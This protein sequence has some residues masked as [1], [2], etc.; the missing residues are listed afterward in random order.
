MKEGSGKKGLQVKL[1][2][3]STPLAQKLDQV[4]SDNN[5]YPT[6]FWL[7]ELDTVE[8][9]NAIGPVSHSLLR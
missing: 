2:P 3:L 4:D 8:V 1:S 5:L 9:C 7:P 6:T